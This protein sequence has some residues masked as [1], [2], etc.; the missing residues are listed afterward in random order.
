M[1]RMLRLDH[2]LYLLVGSLI[3]S[4]VLVC[5]VS[6]SQMAKIAEELHTITTE[7]IPL[8]EHVADITTTQLEQVIQLERMLRE[9]ELLKIDSHA[10]EKLEKAYSTFHKLN[11]HI[12][13]EFK[14]AEKIAAEGIKI[15]HSDKELAAFTS[16]LKKLKAI[17]Q[18]H[19]I[20]EKHVEQLK[21]LIQAGKLAEA[22]KLGDKIEI[23]DEKLDHALESFLKQIEAFTHEALIT[24]EEHEKHA[25]SILIIITLL[26]LGLA[27]LQTWWTIRRLKGRF[28]DIKSFV[29]AFAN[30]HLGAHIEQQPQDDLGQLV[31]DLNGMSKDLSNIFTDIHGL[32]LS[33]RDGAKALDSFAS[34]M[35][36]NA[37]AL[38]QEASLVADA[39]EQMNSDMTNISSATEELNTNMNTVSSAAEELSTNMST[40]A[41]AAEEAS[42]NLSHVAEASNGMNS[43]MST[44]GEAAARSYDNI[45]H[46]SSA[47]EEISTALESMREQC[48]VASRASDDGHNHADQ[49]AQVMSH[50]QHSAQEIVKVVGI[51]KNIADQTNMLALNASIESA[52][53]GEAGKGFAV[54]ANEVKE[55]AKQT[56]DATKMIEDKLNEIRGQVENG[57]QAAQSVA[58][59]V[60]TIKSANLDI[61]NAVESQHD[62]MD[63]LTHAMQN[64]THETQSVTSVRLFEK[65]LPIT[66][67][68]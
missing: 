45:N 40:I 66:C 2:Q 28:G 35:E 11:E 19:H 14:D 49:N 60:N 3:A 65:R 18:E 63:E 32:S 26:T 16:A 27:T 33:I 20:F 15:A 9:M 46:I 4:I 43:S 30:G 23:E 62:G 37:D 44:M 10:K 25:I 67:Y 5:A 39:T 51:I 55:L 42:I 6:L 57:S 17:E 54:V 13:V 22:R 31:Q 1:F 12:S 34:T 52:G 7:D 47:I 56:V 21:G 50:L 58:T 38:K 36:N 59:V 53:A 41:A 64:T 29:Q 24:V 68:I 8:T 48:H 61:L